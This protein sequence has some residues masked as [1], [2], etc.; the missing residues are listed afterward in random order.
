MTHA[1]H[2]K[3]QPTLNPDIAHAQIQRRTDRDAD[4]DSAL[5]LAAQRRR[6]SLESAL[7]AADRTREL[8]D[9]TRPMATR[10]SPADT[11]GVQTPATA[12]DAPAVHFI[13]AATITTA[14]IVALI[15]G[16][17][18]TFIAGVAVGSVL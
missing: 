10:N 15:M 18:M 7:N 4:R 6:E 13:D 16:G 8:V 9:A 17:L 5:E 2:L 14:R 12:P 1:N 11:R 3:R